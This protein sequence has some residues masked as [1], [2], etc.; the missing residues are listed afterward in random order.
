GKNSDLRSRGRAGPWI[1]LR[2]ECEPLRSGD[3]EIVFPIEED[4]VDLVTGESIVN[5]DRPPESFLRPGGCETADEG[6]HNQEHAKPGR[7]PWGRR[8]HRCWLRSCGGAGGFLHNDLVHSRKPSPMRHTT[9]TEPAPVKRRAARRS[10][11]TRAGPSR[12]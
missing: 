11:R 12:G 8:P 5:T 7:G 9:A 6:E 1:D 4:G 10:A 2:S 3:P